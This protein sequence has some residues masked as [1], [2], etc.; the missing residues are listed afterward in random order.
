MYLSEQ[1][2]DDDVIVDAIAK[3]FLSEL[4]MSTIALGIRNILHVPYT[5]RSWHRRYWLERKNNDLFGIPLILH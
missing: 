1:R 3:L 4:G 5:V 2:V